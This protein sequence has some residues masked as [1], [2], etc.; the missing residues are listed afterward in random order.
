MLHTA[1]ASSDF[2][3]VDY[4]FVLPIYM[5]TNGLAFKHAYNPDHSWHHVFWV[6][7]LEQAHVQ[8]F[9]MYSVY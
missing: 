9:L 1:A 6:D 2:T 7:I 4:V 3:G 5:L 8:V